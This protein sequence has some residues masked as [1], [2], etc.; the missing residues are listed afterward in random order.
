MAPKGQKAA[1]FV[2][3]IVESQPVDGYT[4]DTLLRLFGR[5]RLVA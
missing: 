1:P 2:K 4:A 3:A 5:G